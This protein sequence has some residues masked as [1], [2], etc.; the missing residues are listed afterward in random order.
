MD[1]REIGSGDGEWMKLVQD[2]VRWRTYWTGSFKAG[3]SLVN[4]ISTCYSQ[5]T[6]PIFGPGD[7]KIGSKSANRCTVSSDLVIMMMFQ[8]V[9]GSGLVSSSLRS[10][11]RGTCHFKRSGFLFLYVWESCWLG[12]QDTETGKVLWRKWVLLAARESPWWFELTERHGIQQRQQS[13]LQS[14]GRTR[15]NYELTN[16]TS[17]GRK[18]LTSQCNNTHQP[19]FTLYRI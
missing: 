5:C 15:W 10:G 6:D 16:A 11:W 8:A 7:F 1:V 3:K 19:K 12:L 2:R 18:L 14:L 4:W 17:W 9:W 13:W